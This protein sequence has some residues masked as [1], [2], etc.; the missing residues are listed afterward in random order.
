[1][2]T[3]R[4]SKRRQGFF[5]AWKKTSYSNPR[6]RSD[7]PPQQDLVEMIAVDCENG[8]W[9]LGFSIEYDTRGR[10]IQSISK[11]SPDQ[12]EWHAAAADNG[13]YLVLKAV[14]VHA[15]SQR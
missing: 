11:P 7:T 1:V 5:T 12:Y 3:Y 2:L 4:A 15:M 14:C 6:K 10:V 8:R 9:A 13:N